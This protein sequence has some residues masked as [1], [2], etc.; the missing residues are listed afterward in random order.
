MNLPVTDM[1]FVNKA[2]IYC[3]LNSAFQTLRN[4]PGLRSAVE[5]FYNTNQESTLYETN[6]QRKAR[7]IFSEII[8]QNQPREYDIGPTLVD[9]KEVFPNF[10]H[11]NQQDSEEAIDALIGNAFPEEW[12]RLFRME[13][14]Y[15]FKCSCG[16][17]IIKFMNTISF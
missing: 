15:S 10:D 1:R 9:L 6:D 8:L 3:Y 5:D 4:L 16:R 17:V 2:G 14:D 12:K 11:E 7:Q 13:D